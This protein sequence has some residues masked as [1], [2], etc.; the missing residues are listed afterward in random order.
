MLRWI[1]GQYFPSGFDE[2]CELVRASPDSGL[3]SLTFSKYVQEHRKGSWG[4]AAESF[5]LQSQ[6]QRRVGPISE[7]T[8]PVITSN[9]S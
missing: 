6:N 7:L 4:A 9:T 8:L 1:R 2:W 3:P 5:L